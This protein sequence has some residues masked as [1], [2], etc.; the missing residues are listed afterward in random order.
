M[1]AENREKLKQI[2]CHLED[3]LDRKKFFT[4]AEP[5]IADIA[6]LSNVI[7]LKTAFGELGEDYRN[8]RQWYRRCEKL[9]GFDENVA[10]GKFVSDFFK[11]K[12][13]KL[14]PLS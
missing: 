3:F 5:T 8:L 1:S 6:I 12:G 14:A 4:G 10:G 9:T 13:L 2:L 11:A 7:Q